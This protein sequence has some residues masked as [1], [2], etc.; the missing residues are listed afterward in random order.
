M[1]GIFSCILSYKS[2]KCRNITSFYRDAINQWHVFDQSTQAAT[3][4]Q[5]ISTCRGCLGS[6]RPSR[7]AE[8]DG[9][10]TTTVVAISREKGL[11]KK[12]KFG[13]VYQ[14]SIKVLYLERC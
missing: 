9:W 3:S 13:S 10:G 12:P 2:T 4:Q 1:Y 8:C 5:R 14:A 7:W 11:E 6:S